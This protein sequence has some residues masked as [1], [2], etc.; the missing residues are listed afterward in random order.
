MWGRAQRDSGSAFDLGLIFLSLCI[1]HLLYSSS[2]FQLFMLNFP[3]HPESNFISFTNPFRLFPGKTR[4]KDKYRVVYTD[5]QRLELEKEY[6]TSKYITIRRK[7][8]LAQ[9]LQLSERQVKIWFQNR[10]AKDRKTVKKNG[11]DT[12][13]MHPASIGHNSPGL[14]IKPK[15]EGSLLHHPM[16]MGMGMGMGMG[17]LHHFASSHHFGPSSLPPPPSQHPMNQAQQVQ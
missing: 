4:T 13:T 8:E 14:D 9:S 17:Q 3:Y 16:S 1:T 2:M 15:I 5:Y 12:S 10:R 6:H 11:G 7:S